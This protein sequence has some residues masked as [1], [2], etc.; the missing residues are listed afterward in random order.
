ME[1]RRHDTVED[2]RKV[3]V[4]LY[5]RDPVLATV[6]LMVLR[7]RIVDSNPA[8]L[9]TVWHGGAAVGAAFQTL[10]SPLLCGGL[11]EDT[12]GTVA[13]EVARVR[14]DLT[15]A[16]GPREITALFAAQWH[17]AT[18]EVGTVGTRERLHRL[19][20]LHPPTAVTGAIRPAAPA[21]E[22]LL[23]HWLDGF[24][25][26]A[27]GVTV[28]PTARR[29]R[30]ATEPPDQLLIW[31]DNGRPVSMVGVRRPTAGVSRIG[32][33]YTPPERRGHGYG[34]AAICAAAQWA[35][36]A[37]ARDAVLFTDLTNPVVN[38]MY[39]RIG[40]VPVRDFSRIDF[41]K[42]ARA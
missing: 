31:T 30:T 21:D 38:A 12:V 41:S 27:L 25:A 6:E 1:V 40:F 4:D 26:D 35:L 16:H 14:P 8:L 36:H 39:P 7:G 29:G 19:G 37:G 33:L 9:V 20:E 32:P 23:A 42:H 17:A 5:R 28:D 34:S 22:P 15:G 18:G 2:F 13:A 24:R 11:P 3:A 10:R